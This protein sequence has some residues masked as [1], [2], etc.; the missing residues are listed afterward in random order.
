MP[1]G[2]FRGRQYGVESG[3]WAI[4]CGEY[5][6]RRSSSSSSS[7]PQSMVQRH[8]KDL[9]LAYRGTVSRDQGGGRRAGRAGAAG[10]GVPALR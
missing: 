2:N 1:V 10:A 3:G 8:T 4:M 6:A 5:P 9:H 7:H